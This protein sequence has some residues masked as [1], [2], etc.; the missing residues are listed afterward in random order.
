MTTAIGERTKG[1]LELAAA[2][3][4]PAV[5]QLALHYKSMA[6]ELEALDG[7]F[8][9]YLDAGTDATPK[10][11]AQAAFRLRPDD[12]IMTSPAKPRKSTVAKS[13]RDILTEQGPLDMGSLHSA[14]VIRNPDD[15][16]RTREQIRLSVA[17]HPD[18]FCRVSADDRRVCL[19]ETIGAIED[20]RAAVG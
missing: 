14:Y 9:V 5:R 17:R 4:D 12:V 11:A 8:A 3:P 15:A 19:T 13:L 18:Q 10:S 16:G 7:F 6:Q 2:S 20:T 1:A